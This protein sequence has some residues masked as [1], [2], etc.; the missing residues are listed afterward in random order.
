MVLTVDVGNTRIKAAVFEGSTIVENFV[1]EKEELEKEIKKILKK[2]QNCSDLVVA[3]VGNI[4]KQSFLSFEKQLAIHFLTHEDAFPF[5]NKY[6]TPKTL[7]IDRMVLA[8][9]ATL[10]FPRQN[11]LVIDAGTCITYDFIDESDQYLGGAIS[12]G[13]RLR[14]EAL[15]NYTARLPLLSLEA[16]ESYIGNATAQAIHSG[17]VNGFVYEIDGF[18]DEYRTNF[19]NFIIILTGGDADFLAKRLKNTIFANSNFLLESLNQTFQY[20]INN[21]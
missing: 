15:H 19:P 7:G 12:P 21:D 18:I 8:A 3:S 17:V 1:F 11:R 10:Q 9:G 13:L 5:I 4:E 2:F 14:Y 16:P 20:K 6:A